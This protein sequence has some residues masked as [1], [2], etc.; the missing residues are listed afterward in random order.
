MG[1]HPSNKHRRYL[2]ELVARIYDKPDSVRRHFVFAIRRNAAAHLLPRW[3]NRTA[4]RGSCSQDRHLLLVRP[5]AEKRQQ[6]R[7][8]GEYR[9]E[10]YQTNSTT[11]AKK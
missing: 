3:F 11:T 4:H 2:D 1:S 10:P 5:T 6:Q 7:S 8:R 9:L